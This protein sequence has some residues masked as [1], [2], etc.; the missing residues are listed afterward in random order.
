[1]KKL[2]SMSKLRYNEKNKIHFVWFTILVI[3]VTI[4]HCYQKSRA[5]S[6]YKKILQTAAESCSYEVIEL[7]VEKKYSIC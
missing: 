2:R 1:M 5:N 7:L 6:Y 3:C 4:T